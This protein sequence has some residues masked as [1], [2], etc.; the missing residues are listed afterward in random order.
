MA[1][2]V[3][4]PEGGA[5]ERRLRAEPAVGQSEE[6][7]LAPVRPVSPGLIDPPQAGRTVFTT[8]SPEGLVRER[9]E[10]LRAVETAG[11]GSAPLT[12]VVEGAE[13][14]REDELRAVLDAAAH[15]K[16]DLILVLR[17]DIER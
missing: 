17:R 8:A 6:V 1:L 13:E 2:I 10:L 12:V 15:A 16:R 3:Q 4:M 11:A 7:T 14:L 5:L 9:D